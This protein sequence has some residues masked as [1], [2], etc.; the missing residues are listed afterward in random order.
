[1]TKEKDIVLIYIENIPVSFARIESIIADS[2]KDWYHTKL[3]FL[4]IPLQV[5]TWILKDAYING[6]EFSM[7]GKKMRLELVKCPEE[8]QENNLD[9]ITTEGQNKIT[10]FKNKTPE[11][12][13]TSEKKQ[14]PP[15]PPSTQG[16]QD[17]GAEIISLAD[18]RKF[19]N[20]K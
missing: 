5:V 9:N 6:E 19:K 10:Q 7:G 16:E 18:I 3:L 15:P 12:K 2:K 20:K 17:K 4:Q 14:T 11:K 13:T 8:D 1:M